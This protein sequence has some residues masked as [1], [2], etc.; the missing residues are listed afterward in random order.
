MSNEDETRTEKPSLAVINGPPKSF[1][2]RNPSRAF[3]A[4]ASSPFERGKLRS[5]WIRDPPAIQPAYLVRGAGRRRWASA[6]C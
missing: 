1:R 3:F 6:G 5:G 4:V 2:L